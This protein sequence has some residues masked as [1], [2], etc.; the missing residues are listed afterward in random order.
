MG[1]IGYRCRLCVTSNH[2]SI[3]N[4]VPVCKISVLEPALDTFAAQV[5]HRVR[6]LVEHQSEL[7]GAL[8]PALYNR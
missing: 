1:I 3:E 7:L 4:L 6:T 5:A 8:P 2:L